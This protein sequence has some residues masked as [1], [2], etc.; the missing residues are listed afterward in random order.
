MRPG[1]GGRAEVDDQLSPG[2]VRVVARDGTENAAD[3]GQTGRRAR[4]RAPAHGG[5]STGVRGA[6]PRTR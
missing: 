4:P 6:Q 1:V 2:E 3:G 5:Q